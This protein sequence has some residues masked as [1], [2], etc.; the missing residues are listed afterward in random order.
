MTCSELTVENFI[1]Q[2][3][4]HKNRYVLNARTV[5]PECVESLNAQA[6]KRFQLSNHQR[7]YSKSPIR[8]DICE[9]LERRASFSLHEYDYT[10]PPGYVTPIEFF[11]EAQ[12]WRMLLLSFDPYASILQRKLFTDARF[13]ERAYEEKDDMY[14]PKSFLLEQIE[15]GWLG[16]SEFEDCIF[17]HHI[18]VRGALKEGMRYNDL[19]WFYRYLVR[20]FTQMLPEGKLKHVYAPDAA[21]LSLYSERLV[22]NASIVL[23]YS[24]HVLR[25]SDFHTVGWDAFATQSPI[26][27]A[28]CKMRDVLLPDEITLWRYDYNDPHTLARQNSD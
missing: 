4:I 19:V 3:W 13:V 9:W 14:S 10:I 15:L 26:A 25:K 8:I 17:I 18:Q 1:S 12:P 11:S 16:Y 20:A 22:G 7:K 5:T 2:Q 6:F 28:K 21:T 27:A 23:P 24:R